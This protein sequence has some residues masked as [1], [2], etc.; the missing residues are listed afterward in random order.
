[1]R[2]M[3]QKFDGGV[4]KAVTTVAMNAG[5]QAIAGLL[6]RMFVY[7]PKIPKLLIENQQ[8]LKKQEKI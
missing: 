6:C 7:E 1:M 2:N 4:K 3:R 8:K 5:E